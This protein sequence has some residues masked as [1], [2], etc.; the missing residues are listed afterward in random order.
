MSRG[1]VII[2]FFEAHVPDTVKV[3]CLKFR[4]DNQGYPALRDT[5]ICKLPNRE[6]IEQSDRCG[7]IVLAFIGSHIPASAAPDRPDLLSNASGRL[8][9]CH[10]E[11]VH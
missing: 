11:A 5:L 6:L 8:N 2:D 4:Y 10:V 7:F 1:L 9:D 3:L